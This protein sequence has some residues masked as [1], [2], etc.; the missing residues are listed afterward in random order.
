MVVGPARQQ[1]LLGVVPWGGRLWTFWPFH[2]TRV[3][4]G[5]ALLTVAVFYFLFR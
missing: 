3:A 2:G 5:A 4:L 1:D